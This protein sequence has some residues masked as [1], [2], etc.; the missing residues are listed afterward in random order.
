[1]FVRMPTGGG[2]S[3]CMFLIPLSLGNDSLGIMVSPLVGLMEQQVSNFSCLI[4]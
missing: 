1:M 4:A 2:K 3:L